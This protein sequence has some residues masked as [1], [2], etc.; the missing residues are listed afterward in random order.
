MSV[1]KSEQLRVYRVII[2]K[3]EYSFFSNQLK[4]VGMVF[5]HS[6][7][8]HLSSVPLYKSFETSGG[9]SYVKV[10]FCKCIQTNKVTEIK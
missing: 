5:W 6:C 7:L 1:S 10:N 8:S 2:S 3:T 4:N 9:E